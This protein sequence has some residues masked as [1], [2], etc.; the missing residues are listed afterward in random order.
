MSTTAVAAQASKPAVS[1]RA[2]ARTQA[3]SGLVFAVFLIMHLATAASS[4]GGEAAYNGVLSI[5]RS[6]YRFPVI[7][8]AGVIGAALTH[9]V[10]GIWRLVRRRRDKHAKSA[11]VPLRLRIHRYTGYYMTA[12]FVGHVVATRAPSL[13]YGEQP[14]FA[15]LEFSLTSVPWFFYPYYALFAFS[16][17][18]HVVHGVFAALKVLGARWSSV[19]PRSP[20]FWGF[21]AIWSGVALA[22]VLSFGGVIVTA[23]RSHLAQWEAFAERVLPAAFT[24]DR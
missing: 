13:I 22:I 7:E 2:L 23:D 17:G 16:G 15:F 10:S 8:V 14:N 1:D 4:M 11:L 5:V 19:R 24:P 3:I 12:A 20:I 21:A 18:Y 9:I 6:Y